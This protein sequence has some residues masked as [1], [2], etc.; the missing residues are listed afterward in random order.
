MVE[1][2]PMT[3]LAPPEGWA[4]TLGDT[5]ITPELSHCRPKAPDDVSENTVP[6]AL[7]REMAVTS[8]N[9]L[10]TPGDH[11]CGQRGVFRQHS[12]SHTAGEGGCVCPRR[13][14]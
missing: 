9:L 2:S 12:L 1:M 7:A 4:V 3:P 5:L 13:R 14:F 8:C 11:G 10:Q 6:V